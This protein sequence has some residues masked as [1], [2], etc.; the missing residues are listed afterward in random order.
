MFTVIPQSTFEEMQLD[1][2]VVLYNFD[3]ANPAAPSES[4]FVCA[5]TGGI[6]VTCQPT[7]ID[8]G[9]D[10]DNVPNNMKEFKQLDYWTCGMQFT[11]LGTSA[12]S[13][14][15]SLGPAD[16]NSSDNSVTPRNELRSTDFQDLWWVGD[17]A[18]GGFVAVKLMNALSAEGFSLQTTKKGKGQVSVNLTGHY[19][20]SSQSGV[21]MKFYSIEG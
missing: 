20:I 11:S 10:V 16:V 6:Q 17:R 4:D 15:L 8:L 13:I 7:Y 3:P 2:G 14:R 18:D 19:S 12:D 9:E 1:A 5:T 21:P